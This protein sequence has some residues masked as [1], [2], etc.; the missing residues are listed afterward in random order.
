MAKAR[1][2]F[3]N[4]SFWNT[5]VPRDAEADPRSGH[6]TDLLMQG[7]YGPGFGINTTHWTIPVYEVDARTP[8]RVMHQRPNDFDAHYL[9]RKKPFRH[10]PGFGPEIPIP[11]HAQPD[12]QGDA[13]MAMVDWAA[14][15]AW[16][17][18]AV[19]K[20]PDGEWESATGMTYAL[21]GS[22]VFAS[23]PDGTR[24][25]S[26]WDSGSQREG[27]GGK[28]SM[29]HPAPGDSIHFHGPSR[30]A[31]VPAIAGLIMLDEM[32]AGR[33][34][35]KLAFA[36][37]SNGYQEFVWPAAWSDGMTDG[38]IPEGAV[39]QLDPSLDLRRFD[40]GPGGLI[41]ARALQ[42][43]G[44]VDVDVAGGN[45]LYAEHP[46]GKPGMTWEGV[47]DPFCIS[48]IDAKHF[49]VLK[50]GEVV[51]GGKSRRP[52]PPVRDK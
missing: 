43:Y 36:C 38:G 50:L 18:W 15:R 2:F 40:L 16:D 11:D 35:H 13:H 44:A 5:P 39:L 52:T 46:F 28:R 41:V 29:F 8:R 26:R 14:M 21:D 10:G 3:S 37:R 1:R 25:S 20:R 33:I 48:R 34:E 22:G 17:M 31:G 32:R 51:H 45:A 24:L 9:W 6:F 47:L 19:H 27:P 7:L 23:R 12:P 30:A 49:R 4:D 42:E